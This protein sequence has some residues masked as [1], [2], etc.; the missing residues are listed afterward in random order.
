[1]DDDL[2]AYLEQFLALLDE[3][4]Q[5]SETAKLYRAR[6]GYLGH[7]DEQ[8]EALIEALLARNVR[9]VAMGELMR[10]AVEQILGDG[11]A[12]GERKAR[13]GDEDHDRGAGPCSS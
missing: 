6:G 5:P 9:L 8:R 3:T 13:V 4:A 12:P 1:M 11:A 2:K 10:R 7:T